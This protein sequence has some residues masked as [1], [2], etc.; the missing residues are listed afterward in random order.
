MINQYVFGVINQ[1][2]FGHKLV[3]HFLMQRNLTNF[4]IK[5]T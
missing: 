4:A 5:L 1:Y 2:V 3:I